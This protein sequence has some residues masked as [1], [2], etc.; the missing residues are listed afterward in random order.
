[1]NKRGHRRGKPG[2]KHPFE[3]VRRSTECLFASDSRLEYAPP[4]SGEDFEA[5]LDTVASLL[6]DF[7]HR[8]DRDELDGFVVDFPPMLGS[9]VATLAAWTRTL[10]VGLAARDATGSGELGYVEDPRWAF[11]FAGHVYFVLT[12]GPCYPADSSRFAFGV[13]RTFVLLQPI[14][15]FARRRPPGSDE[16]APNAR[17]QIREAYAASGR[18]YDLAL[19]LSPLEAHR[20]VKPAAYGQPPVRWWTHDEQP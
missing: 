9:Q 19:T 3:Q 4:W 15:A 18:P 13:D 10:L 8:V 17:Q 12:T 16:L 7:T 5:H 1:M 6:L 20:F 11:S 14:A 2:E